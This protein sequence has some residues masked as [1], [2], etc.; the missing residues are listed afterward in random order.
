LAGLI[1]RYGP[2]LLTDGQ[3]FKGLKEEYETV[4]GI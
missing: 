4:P 1:E 2:E 3:P